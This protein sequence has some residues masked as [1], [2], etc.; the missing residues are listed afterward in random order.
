MELSSNS[1]E[2]SGDSGQ[3]QRRSRVKGILEIILSF[4]P[5][6]RWEPEGPG[7]TVTFAQGP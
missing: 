4:C 2:P 1:G 3:T 6:F 5:F 7:G